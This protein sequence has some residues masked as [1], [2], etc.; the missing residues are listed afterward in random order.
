MAV[1]F[2]KRPKQWLLHQQRGW[3]VLAYL[4]HSRSCAWAKHRIK[5]GPNRSFS[6]DCWANNGPIQV[7]GNI[8]SWVSL[9]RGSAYYGVLVLIVHIVYDFWIGR[10]QCLLCLYRDPIELFELVVE[11]PPRLILVPGSCTLLAA[12][13]SF[14]APFVA[15]FLLSASFLLAPVVLLPRFFYI[16]DP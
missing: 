16:S 13:L 1:V 7:L 8:I 12:S 3:K 6:E 11:R 10:L 2:L 9:T 5:V 15:P 4:N 14:S